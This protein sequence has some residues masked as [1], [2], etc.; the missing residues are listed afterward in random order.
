MDPAK[1]AHRGGYS[2][3]P[4]RLSLRNP[5]TFWTLLQKTISKWND[6]PVLRFGAALAY[7][8]AF[9]VV[10]LIVV[11][12]EIAALIVGHNAEVH[13]LKQIEEIIGE[14]S[15]EALGHL[16]A[17]SS[18]PSMPASAVP[19]LFPLKMPWPSAS[20]PRQTSIWSNRKGSVEHPGRRQ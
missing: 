4:I 9:S 13:L 20:R 15:A 1:T 3:S 18:R 6:D 14:Q 7:Y 17:P 11:V 5:R 12:L 19:A 10:P 16:L 2:P 8:T